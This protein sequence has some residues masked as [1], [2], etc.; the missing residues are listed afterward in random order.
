MH[1]C[2]TSD[3]SSRSM[4]FF[5]LEHACADGMAIL[6]VLSRV[7][8]TVDGRPLPP[9]TFQRPKPSGRGSSGLMK[10]LGFAWD[11]ITSTLKYA[12]LPTGSFDSSCP[13]HPSKPCELLRFG[14][15]QLVAV[16]PHSLEKIKKIKNAAGAGTTVNDVVY[17]AFAGACRRYCEE[18]GLSDAASLSLRALVPVAF[19]RAADCPLTNDWT[20]V[21]TAVP[22]K[23]PTAASRVAATNSLFSKLKA[24]PEAYVARFLTAANSTAPPCVFGFVG[25]SLLSRHTIVFSNVPGPA[26]QIAVGGKPVLGILPVYPNLIPQLLCVSYNGTMCMTLTVDPAAISDPE[27]LAQL[28]LDELNVLA[29]GAPSV[30]PG[31][32]V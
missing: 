3:P 16:P 13:L 30:Q 28:Y 2:T 21:S 27:R 12:N 19:P 8:T 20:F 25:R 24:S 23:P 10:W 17:G 7:A 14:E 15:R 4:L 6:Q 11:L 9:A 22:L 1:L 18:Q 31:I 26:E 29:E 5:R 32:A